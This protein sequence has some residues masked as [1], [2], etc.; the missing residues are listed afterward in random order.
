MN[1][2][3]KPLYTLFIYYMLWTYQ[4]YKKTTVQ[5]GLAL[6]KY[7]DETYNH[8]LLTFIIHFMQGPMLIN[9]NS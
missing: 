5:S 7:I 6:S 8:S 2:L 9:Y 1:P 3:N 4:V